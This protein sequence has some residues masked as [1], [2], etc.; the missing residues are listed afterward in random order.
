MRYD[1][2]AYSTKSLQGYLWHV[3]INFPFEAFILLLTQLITRVGGEAVERAWTQVTQVYQHHPEFVT[4]ARNALYHALGNLTLKAWDTRAGAVSNPLSPKQQVEPPCI[5]KVRMQ[6]NSKLR[7]VPL[8]PFPAPCELKTQA[9][10]VGNSLGETDRLP[11]PASEVHFPAD[12]PDWDWE[13]WQSLLEG[14]GG[15]IF[16]GDEQA[17]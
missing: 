7:P 9:Y 3:V 6:R 4:E 10:Q 11:E 2:L 17:L 8:N 13:Y 15:S 12:T 16:D 5:A 1:N 14:R